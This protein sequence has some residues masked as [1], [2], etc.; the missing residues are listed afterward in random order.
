MFAWDWSALWDALTRLS[1]SSMMVAV[2]VLPFQHSPML[3]HLASSHTVAKFSFLSPFSRYSYL[4]PWGALCL[5]QAGLLECCRVCPV[6][7]EHCWGLWGLQGLPCECE[8]GTLLRVAFNDWVLQALPCITQTLLRSEFNDVCECCRLCHVAQSCH[9]GFCLIW[10]I[11]ML[12]A[13]P[14]RSETLL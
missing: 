8:T 6:R 2:P 12:Q 1:P 7:K 3:G 10:M 14:W 9:C 11:W 4:S 13:L 5:S